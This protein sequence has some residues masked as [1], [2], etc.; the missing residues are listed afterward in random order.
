MLTNGWGFEL[1]DGETWHLHGYRYTTN[2][3]AYGRA[4]MLCVSPYVA[5]RLLPP[6]RTLQRIYSGF[7]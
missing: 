4:K 3:E 5:Y 1:F 2:R 6:R 7:R